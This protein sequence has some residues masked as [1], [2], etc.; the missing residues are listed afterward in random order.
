M[1]FFPKYQTKFGSEIEPGVCFAFDNRGKLLIAISIEAPDP[2]EPPNLVVLWPEPPPTSFRVIHHSA[3]RAQPLLVLP[4][5]RISLP[6]E[7][8]HIRVGY[9]HMQDPIG[10]AFLTDDHDLGLILS[11]SEKVSFTTGK[12]LKVDLLKHGWF[13]RWQI[14]APDANQEWRALCSVEAF[15]PK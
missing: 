11:N 12:P 3:I 8:E 6:I 14:V 13:P 10:A 1:D 9:S 15:L 5:T 2:V 7:P 4:N